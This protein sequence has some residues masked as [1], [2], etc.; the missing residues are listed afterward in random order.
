M[1]SVQEGEKVFGLMFVTG[2]GGTERAD[3]SGALDM[4]TSPKSKNVLPLSTKL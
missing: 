1:P 3:F 2:T 4:I